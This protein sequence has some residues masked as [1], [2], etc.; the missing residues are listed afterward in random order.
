MD[1]IDYVHGGDARGG[2]LRIVQATEEEQA[3]ITQ[4]LKERGAEAPS[5]A[6]ALGTSALMSAGL[7]L[8]G[9]LFVVAGM[10]GGLGDLVH[11]HDSGGGPA[12]HAAVRREEDGQKTESGKGTTDH[13]PQDYGEKAFPIKLLKQVLDSTVE[14]QA[15]IEQIF[16][17]Q[18]L[19]DWRKGAPPPEEPGP[20][21][22]P[23]PRGGLKAFIEGDPASGSFSIRVAPANETSQAAA[24]VPQSFDQPRYALRRDGDLWYLT[25]KGHQAVL[26]HEQGICYVAEMLGHPGERLKKLNLAAKYSSPKSKGTSGIE[27]YDPA[28]G[29]CAAPSSTE[30]LHELSLANDENEVRTACRERARELKE[31]IDDPSET[32]TA[33][34]EARQELEEIAAHLSK[35]SRQ[36]RG[37][38]KAAADSIRCA[39]KKLLR[40]LLKPAGSAASPYAVRREFAEHIEKYLG[41]PS[42]RYAAPRARKA[43]GELTGCLLY[44]PPAGTSWVVRQ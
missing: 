24:P 11:L 28:T 6:P 42:G 41:T 18:P 12:H 40:N 7:R 22:M 43:R 31:T 13:G 3:A 21:Q 8:A 16:K 26:T 5:A 23:G 4:L 44:E 14:L 39:I 34:E 2:G 10:G 15:A 30:A 32:E 9:V 38:T 37:P 17:G 29:K 20:S 36:F 27:V 19:P 1:G 35:D 33:K 25:I